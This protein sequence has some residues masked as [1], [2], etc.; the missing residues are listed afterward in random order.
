[1]VDE[2]YLK[3]GTLI[4]E[5]EWVQ[6]IN[7]LELE[8]KN[9]LVKN[10]FLSGEKAVDKVEGVLKNSILSRTTLRN[11]VLF[12]GGID[13]TLIAFF[14]KKFR[15]NLV[16]YTVGF[17][18]SPDL[19][20]A[21]RVADELGFRIKYR[22]VDDDTLLKTITKVVNVLNSHDK[23][24][25]GVGSVLMLASELAL[26][27]NTVNLFSG[28][29]S[30]EIFAGYQRHYNTFKAGG[31][32][33]ESC[34]NGLKTMYFRDLVRDYRISSQLR[35]KLRTPFLDEEL[36]RVA[37]RLSPYEKISYKHKKLI[38]RKIALKN[39]IRDYIALRPKKAAQY[40]TLFEK[41]M[42]RI[43]KSAGYKNVEDYLKN[44]LVQNA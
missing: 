42:I 29:G 32:V 2:F 12:S 18:D 34:W 28:L 44:I 36:M 13:S 8:V 33:N 27:D 1:M 5:E 24:R 17:E 11:G 7:K 14:L 20:M 31:D 9:A 39:N 30:E 41:R 21:L 15:A 19:N 16:C 4:S 37:M 3:R 38:L 40:G 6:R 10:G 23:M 22:I 25:V 43:A 26:K 35:I